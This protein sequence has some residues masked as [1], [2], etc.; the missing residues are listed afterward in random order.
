[1]NECFKHDYCPIMSAH[2]LGP[3]SVDASDDGE[4]VLGDDSRYEA[5]G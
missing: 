5:S 2:C 1:M 4:A 3:F